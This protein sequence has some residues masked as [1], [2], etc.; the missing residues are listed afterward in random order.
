MSL[1]A[2]GRILKMTPEISSLVPWT[3]NEIKYHTLDYVK[4]LAKGILL[5]QLRFPIGS[6]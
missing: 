3:M 4:F 1:I 5:M 6:L 2:V